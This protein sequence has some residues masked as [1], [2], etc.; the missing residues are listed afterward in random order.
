MYM[1]RFK[2]GPGW[3]CLQ[4]LMLEIVFYVNYLE[5]I[6]YICILEFC[7]CHIAEQYALKGNI[8]G[9]VNIVSYD[10][11]FVHHVDPHIKTTR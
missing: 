10:L 1:T 2:F 3:L 5:Y 4:R 7:I 11:V 8:S 6:L 9:A